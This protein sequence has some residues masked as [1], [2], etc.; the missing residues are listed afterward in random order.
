M[1]DPQSLLAAAQGYF[2]LGMYQAAYDELDEI[3]AAFKTSEEVLALRVCILHKLESW[4]LAREVAA[5]LREAA[6]DNS[7]YVIWEGYATRRA[8]GLEAAR[9]VL[10]GAREAHPNEPIVFFNLACYNSQL[11]NLEE[12]KE[13]LARAIAIDGNDRKTAL[14]DPDLEPVWESWKK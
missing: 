14:D 13:H 4:E 3:P 12:A 2:E 5:F 11:G 6:P 9:A 10:L 7:Q 1:N 8:S